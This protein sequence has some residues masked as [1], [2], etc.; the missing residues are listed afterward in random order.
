MCF[1][2]EAGAAGYSLSTHEVPCPT[3]F[4]WPWFTGYRSVGQLIEKVGRW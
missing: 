4:L 3:V 2:A 1:L